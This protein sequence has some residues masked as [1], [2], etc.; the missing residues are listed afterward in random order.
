MDL[1][2]NDEQ[3]NFT[4]VYAIAKVGL[5]KLKLTDESKDLT[6]L[7]DVIL[8]HVAPA[9]SDELS[10]MPLK[11]QPFNLGYDN[12]M[13]RLAVARIY[14]GTIKNRQQCLCQKNYGW[15]SERKN[16]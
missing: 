15:S 7:L 9:G 10:Q 6:P 3:L 1:G 8:K 11:V 13:G 12:F 16:F 4:T 14:Q 2:A 5:A